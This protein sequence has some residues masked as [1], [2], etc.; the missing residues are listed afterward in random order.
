MRGYSTVVKF[1]PNLRS[2]V[3]RTI[4][5]SEMPKEEGCLEEKKKAAPCSYCLEILSF[6]QGDPEFLF[7]TG[8]IKAEPSERCLGRLLS[9]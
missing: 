9:P 8:H 4:R 6:Y 7:H 2:N 1:F 5:D 3:N